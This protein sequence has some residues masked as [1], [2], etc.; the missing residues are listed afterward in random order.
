ME[1]PDAL[2]RT[3]AHTREDNEPLS[4]H[5]FESEY[6]QEKRRKIIEDMI[7]TN[8]DIWIVRGFY[9][10]VLLTVIAEIYIVTHFAMR[11]INWLNS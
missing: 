1:H 7:K 6:I 10:I 9:F 5:S 11:F 8:K 4:K 3:H 2:Q